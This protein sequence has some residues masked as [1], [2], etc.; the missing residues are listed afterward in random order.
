MQYSA[1]SGRDAYS[2]PDWRAALWSGVIAGLVFMLAEM[3]LV[4]KLQ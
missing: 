2:E 4:V 3:L 1:R